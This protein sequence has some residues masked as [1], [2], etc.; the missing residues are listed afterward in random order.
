M[1]WFRHDSTAN[2]DSK[3]KKL[4]MRYG[5]KGYG[6][7]W[8]CL[9]LIACKVEQ[10]SLTFDLE[11]DAEI[12][13]FDLGIHIDEVNEM[14]T[15]MV[16]L[17]LFE[18]SHGVITCLKLAKRADEYT[19]KFL[20]KSKKD[21]EKIGID[22]GH[23]PDKVETKSP[24]KEIKE[25]KIIKR[26][27]QPNPAKAELSEDESEDLRLAS[28]MYETLL[29]QNPSH[30]KPNTQKW[31]NSIRLMR[32]VEKRTWQEIADV[33]QW[34]RGDEFWS[35][36]I[37]SPDKLRKQ[38]DALVLKNIGRGADNASKLIE[39]IATDTSWAE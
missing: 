30:K 5:L 17:E 21:L 19:V 34:A 1:K 3:L 36:N 24:P 7:Y 32:E 10:N 39:H 38:F 27:A 18:S 15:Y 13:A 26:N 35:S 12:L 6:L 9:E 14:M 28:W 11:H 23:C 37:L 2:Q 29:S 20:R 4:R 16:D 31:A 25:N 8:Y 22:T 33:W